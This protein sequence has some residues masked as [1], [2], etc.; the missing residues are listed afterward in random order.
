MSSVYLPTSSSWYRYIDQSDRV[1]EELETEIDVLIKRQAKEACQLMENKEYRKDFW[2]WDL[3]WTATDLM[4]KQTRKRSQPEVKPSEGD[5]E[6]ERLE[7]K[8]KP[9]LSRVEDLYK[10][11][12]RCP[13]YP[14]WYSDLCGKFDP[15]KFAEPEDL[16]VGKAIVPKLLRLTWNGFP[17]V[18]H[19]HLK[20]GYMIPPDGDKNKG[21]TKEIL[22][23]FVQIAQEADGDDEIIKE[24]L[25]KWTFV[26]LP[27][28]TGQGN[29]GN[30]LSK[31]FLEAVKTGVLS[32]FVQDKGNNIAEKIHAVFKSLS[33]WRSS[34]DR[35]KNQIVVKTPEAMAIL[36]Q[37]VT[38]GT[39]TRRAVE[40][41]WLTASNAKEDRVGSELK[42]VIQAPKGYK[43]V[44]ADVDSQELWIAAVIGDA[45]FTK[46]HGSTAL[47]WMTLQ[48]SK[49]D[50]SDMHSK[51]AS[52]IGVSRNEAKVLNYGRIYGAG[53]PFAAQLIRN[54]NPSLSE[55]E[56]KKKSAE[57]YKMT[58]GERHV[59][60]SR[61]GQ[62]IHEVVFGVKADG[63]IP[64]KTLY[65]LK[66]YKP[67]FD[68]FLESYDSVDEL[69][70]KGELL[71]VLDIDEA[72]IS[73]DKFKY[74]L[75][76]PRKRLWNKEK[77]FDDHL[78]ID[79]SDLIDCK[80]WSG[81]TESH[82]FNKLEEIALN[83]WSQTPVLNCRISDA[84]AG[85]VVSNDFLPSRINWVV[86]SSAVDYLHLLLAAMQWMFQE[87]DIKGRF[88][89]SIHDE[90]RYLVREEDAYRA[91]LAL[92][93][94]NMF[95]RAMFC[96]ELE[97]NSLPIDVAFFS[98]VDVDQVMRKEPSADCV[99]PSNPQGLEWGY[100]IKNGE[101]LTM[102]EII[103]LTK[104]KLSKIAE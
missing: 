34:R 1:M 103:D 53:I 90:V 78:R 46:E 93:M 10:T 52:A 13:G 18:R 62:V 42:A 63:P 84:L 33:Y 60:L 64:I 58:K 14:K 91:A 104:G 74:D 19:E 45:H 95:V 22:E 67:I 25:E 30:P 98:G 87:Y 57:M 65:K 43:L 59:A 68:Y 54:F 71:P 27:H 69:I 8:F 79:D 3:D 97:M 80:V 94:A 4:I 61:R 24:H 35:I 38:C 88:V 100:G 31:G 51:T 47:G 55:E 32:S 72:S 92:Q 28:P 49:A 23:K 86:Q 70:L 29:V 11:Q 36:P 39:L 50:G 66:K 81:G 99:T 16:G 77:R 12:P 75:L 6:L 26:Q 21:N 76:E 83:K 2:L 48:G 101:C 15:T 17:I 37:V 7:K 5:T 96:Q 73:A 82:S 44:G 9:L 102:K 56:A 41:T 89:I 20:W 85:K 40:K